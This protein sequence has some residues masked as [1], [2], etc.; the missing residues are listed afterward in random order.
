MK[1]LDFTFDKHINLRL[2]MEDWQQIVKLY[3]KNQ[4]V[5]DSPA[6]VIRAAIHAFLRR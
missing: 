1:V 2:R 4:D 5:Y 6:H 3:E